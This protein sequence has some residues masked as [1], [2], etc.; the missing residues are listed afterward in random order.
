MFGTRYQYN[1][2]YVTK[3]S[4]DALSM[5]YSA[6][7]VLGPIPTFSNQ[8]V[9]AIVEAIRQ[10]NLPPEIINRV[11]GLGPIDWSGGRVNALSESRQLHI[12]RVLHLTSELV[13]EDLT[14]VKSYGLKMMFATLG[15]ALFLVGRV[16]GPCAI[17]YAGVS[18]IIGS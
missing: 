11:E 18:T 17:L 4:F 3:E 15:N 9:G 1:G 7:D 13:E 6:Y 16:V 8:N 10:I 12:E 14:P 2:V 5:F